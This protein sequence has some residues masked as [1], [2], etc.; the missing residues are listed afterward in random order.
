MNFF[1][2]ELRKIVGDR[3]PDTTFV[4]RACYV[5]LNEMNSV[6]L[7]CLRGGFYGKSNKDRRRTSF[8]WNGA[9]QWIEKRNGCIDSSLCISQ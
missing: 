5:R 2:Q 7:K 3:S 4:G 1:E 8:K 9:Y 6:K